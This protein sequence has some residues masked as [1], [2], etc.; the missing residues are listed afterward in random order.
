MALM[1]GRVL[2]GE[3]KNRFCDRVHEFGRF[4]RLRLLERARRQ[5]RPAGTVL[6]EREKS[7]VKCTWLS[8]TRMEL[9]KLVFRRESIQ[10]ILTIE[11]RCCWK[12]L[13][14]FF[15]PPISIIF[16]RLHFP[17][18]HANKVPGLSPWVFF[19]WHAAIF[20]HSSVVSSA[21]FLSCRA[22]QV[23]TSDC[24]LNHDSRRRQRTGLISTA[25][26][27]LAPSKIL[28]R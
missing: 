10:Q 13:V 15:C 12:Q 28:F 20:S 9:V 24:R 7:I 27:I 4:I 25:I 14:L 16:G 26:R 19:R 2:L 1:T 21:R 17:K 18:T 3:E 5:L 23:N 6:F 22:H 8:L 11:R